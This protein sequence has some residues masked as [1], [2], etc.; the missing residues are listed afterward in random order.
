M[1]SYVN[2]IQKINKKP[3]ATESSS[4]RKKLS[5]K[6]KDDPKISSRFM[7]IKYRHKKPK[8]LRTYSK[9]RISDRS[10]TWLIKNYSQRI[11]SDS[12]NEDT[13][14]LSCSK[15]LMK[16]KDTPNR[17]TLRRFLRSTIKQSGV[18]TK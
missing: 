9:E 8:I 16:T 17:K 5:K 7:N 18:L 14:T 12:I 13:K 2:S 4:F 10:S 15:S 6:K 1:E 3:S 11:I